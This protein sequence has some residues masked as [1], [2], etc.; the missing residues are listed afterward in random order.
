MI[1][2]GVSAA[3]LFEFALR[4]ANGDGDFGVFAMDRAWIT[5]EAFGQLKPTYSEQAIKRAILAVKKMEDYQY[6][7]IDQL[8][9][10]L[11]NN[12][13]R[14]DLDDPF[15]ARPSTGDICYK[16]IVPA[17]TEEK[18]EY[19]DKYIPKAELST[20]TYFVSH[21]WSYPFWC[22]V[23]GVVAH[24]LECDGGAMYTNSAETILS[25]LRNV[26]KKH[27]YWIDIFFKNQHIV[28]SDNTAL[29]LAECVQNAGNLLL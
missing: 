8:L 23:E 6:T 29:E 21:S 7:E 12:S 5:S 3:W 19:A 22:L 16:T 9:A 26:Q 25:R 11:E 4:V 17:T 13:A 20:A 28:N 27:F 14:T 2:T 10:W 15:P 24:Q 18:I 1:N